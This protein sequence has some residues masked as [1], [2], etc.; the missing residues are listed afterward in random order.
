[1]P[2]YNTIFIKLNPSNGTIPLEVQHPITNI[3]LSTTY[4]G[5]D[6]SYGITLTAI[7]AGTYSQI[8]VR[9]L[10]SL[11]SYFLP[12]SP[13]TILDDP[14]S[15][16]LSQHVQDFS[17][18]ITGA[19]GAI[20]GTQQT[21]LDAL[22]TELVNAGLWSKIQALYPFINN[23]EGSKFNFKDP[24][25][26]KLTHFGGI[27][28]SNEGLVS[29]GT[30]YYDTGYVPAFNASA[31]DN[32]AVDIFT[33]FTTQSGFSYSLGVGDYSG[34]HQIGIYRAEVVENH[35]DTTAY[36]STGDSTLNDQ[37]KFVLNAKGALS[38]QRSTGNLLQ[39]YQN[40]IKVSEITST[41]VGLSGQGFGIYGFAKN[42]FGGPNSISSGNHKYLVIREAMTDIQVA[43]L[44][45]IL[46]KYLV[47]ATSVGKADLFYGDSITHA[48]NVPN[49][50]AKLYTQQTGTLMQNWAVSSQVG[51]TF[52]TTGIASTQIATYNSAIHRKLFLGHGTN[53]ILSG[54][55][56]SQYASVLDSLITIA[57][58]K[59]WPASS[60]YVIPAWY[61]KADNNG[62]AR[63]QYL[64]SCTTVATNRGVVLVDI[65]NIMKNSSNPD[66]VLFTPSDGT[67]PS[68]AGA[69]FV[70]DQIF[71]LVG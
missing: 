14:G 16:Q 25:T 69:Q 67:H 57:I 39:M 5:S 31:V 32:F 37:V 34:S 60:I 44:Y 18:V 4:T 29:D 51:D 35:S 38:I 19:G 47:S 61:Q 7:P 46:E 6:R 64:T 70:A 49:S 24:S 13:I 8:K 27:S 1:M 10:G 62:T 36:I 59:G 50:W 12:I 9:P 42:N 52:L 45:L 28:I 2:T 43:N 65:Y 54:L 30:G 26:F 22:Y 56:A 71:Q 11:S 55:T 41:P 3:W 20:T 17:S 48:L 68:Q 58:N 63:Q 21:N 53:D 15:A 33:D 40:G 23:L 66:T